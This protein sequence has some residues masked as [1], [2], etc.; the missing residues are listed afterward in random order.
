MTDNKNTS[1]LFLTA[2]FYLLFFSSGIPF[3]WDNHEF[4]E[5]FVNLPYLES[6]QQLI[7]PTASTIGDAPRATYGILVRTLFILFKHE[8]FFWIVAKTL[9][10]AGTIT[11][12]YLLLR[13]IEFSKKTAFI[14]TLALLTNYPVYFH[15][16]LFA[17]P[18]IIAEFFKIT[19]LCMLVKD[20]TQ[21]K[22][23]WKTQ[24]TIALLAIPALR[25]YPPGVALVPTIV[26]FFVF[27][28]FRYLKR[29]WL[30]TL[31][32]LAFNFPRSLLTQGL[33][34]GLPLHLSH[35]KHLFTKDLPTAWLSPLPNLDL[36]YYLSF[37]NILSF[38]GIIL[39]IIS[40]LI[41]VKNARRIKKTNQHLAL[42]LA[43]AWLISEFPILIFAPDPAIRYLSGLLPAITIL[44]SLLYQHAHTTISKPNKKFYTT[45][46]AIGISSII[47]TNIGYTFVFRA[48]WG[49]AFVGYELVVQWIDEQQQN[50]V[51]ALYHT[52]SVADEYVHITKGNK[53]CLKKD[54]HYFRAKSIA[55]FSPEKLEAF[56]KKYDHFYVIKRISSKGRSEYP[57]L[58]LNKNTHLKLVTTIYGVAKTPFDWINPLF[59]KLFN[60]RPNTF[61][62]YELVK[63]KSYNPRAKSLNTD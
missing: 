10:F 45:V 51:G 4:H 25:S 6:L 49:S 59:M 35:L 18:F 13:K 23:S 24:L 56:A 48:T 44:L 30:L 8:F 16:L 60:Y 31:Y 9:F 20:I 15:T 37:Y 55:D 3:F 50:N 54:P 11:A 33:N 5:Y 61:Y 21:E 34:P 26:L 28:S 32:L 41:L 43:I 58:D 14:A 47:L 27:T 36:L 17:E 1:L 57:P 12:F 40:L 62:V 2:F 38:L 52:T 46:L 42:P 19:I 63:D 39:T 29:Y 53:Y 22:T 7:T